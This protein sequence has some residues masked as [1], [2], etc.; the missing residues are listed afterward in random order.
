MEKSITI[1]NFITKAL[2]LAFIYVVLQL[3]LMFF[4][5]LVFEVNLFE[6][7]KNPQDDFMSILSS[8]E[9]KL[10]VVMNQLLGMFFPALIFLSIIYRK[11]I[12][13]Q[14]DF[15]ISEKFEL[16]LIGLT[17]LFFS[18]PLI[19]FLAYINLQI[20]LPEWM[21]STSGEIES[22]MM[23]M[24][25]MDSPLDLIINILVIA[26]LPAISE[27]LLFRGL[28]QKEFISVFRND[29]LAILFTAILFSAFHLQFEGF[30]PRVGL[31]LILGYA[32]YYSKSFFI[33]VLMHFT[34]N[35]IMLLAVYLRQDNLAL[36]SEISYSLFSCILVIVS[37]FFVVY[38]MRLIW[39]KE[40]NYG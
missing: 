15:R 28:F 3:I 6:V 5:W 7:D 25:N 2:I 39:L 11:K 35:A 27:E 26:L 21:M 37:G 33:P 13:K 24:I 34:N 14:I 10:F 8:G 30:L 20:E 19:Q 12:F 38:L 17:L 29:H 4:V 22:Y 31:G 1:N 18:Y 32:Y 9:L 36:E 40:K 16:P 23:R